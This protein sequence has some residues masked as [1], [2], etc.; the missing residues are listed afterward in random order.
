MLAAALFVSA[1]IPSASV[2][3]SVG[4]LSSVVEAKDFKVAVQGGT[5]A[6]AAPTPTPVVAAPKPTPTPA[7]APPQVQKADKPKAQA[8]IMSFCPYGLQMLKAYVPVMELLGDKADLQV[9]FVPYAM[10][11]KNEVDGNNYIYCVQKD[12]KAKLPAYLRCF[13]E[14]GDYKGCLATA[15]VDTAKTESCVSSLD[16]QFNITGLFND[17]T[18]WL[19]GRYP[20]YPVQQAEAEQFGVQGS[21]T[22]VLN[23]QQ[24]PVSRSAEAIKQ[25]VCAGFKTAPAECARTLSTNQEAPSTGKIGVGATAG[26]AAAAGGC[27]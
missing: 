14:N 16:S 4:G 7:P 15:G 26:A 25:A 27:G 9:G 8:Y 17:Q 5:Q 10:H 1:L 18:T 23:G 24:V 21:P 6:A 19:S 12:S 3:F 20:Q 2:Y 22:F 13:V 11:G